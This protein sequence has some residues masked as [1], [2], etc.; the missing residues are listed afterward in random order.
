[1]IFIDLLLKDIDKPVDKLWVMWIKFGW[2]VFSITSLTL[3]IH[4]ISTI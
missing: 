2:Q 3:N 1:M 4:I